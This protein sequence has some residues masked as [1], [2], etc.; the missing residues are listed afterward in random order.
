MAGR[1][2]EFENA[3]LSSAILSSPKRVWQNNVSDPCVV[4]Y[5]VVVLQY[6]M[7][8]VPALCNTIVV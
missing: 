4:G 3:I 1:K 7:S 6:Y 8:N 5:P 2:R